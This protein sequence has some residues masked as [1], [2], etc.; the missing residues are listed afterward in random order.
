MRGG[1]AVHVFG[2]ITLDS[3]VPDAEPH[4]WEAEAPESVPSMRYPIPPRVVA[5]GGSGEAYLVRRPDSLVGRGKNHLTEKQAR[6]AVNAKSPGVCAA[7]AGEFDRISPRAR[8][9]EEPLLH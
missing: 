3:A 1:N 7:H 5:V 4:R 6:R 2:S 9:V 8:P